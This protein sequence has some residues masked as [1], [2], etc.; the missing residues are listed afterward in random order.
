M[1]KTTEKKH[2]RK[3]PITPVQAFAEAHRFLKNAKETIAKSPIEHS[4]YQDTK[5]VREA[6][7]IAYLSALRAMDAYLLKKGLRDDEL[8]KSYEGY[9]AAKRKYIPLN[10]KLRDYLTIVYENLHIPAYYDG[11]S[12]V[13]VV[14]E[15]FAKC[16]L[17][18]EMLEKL[19]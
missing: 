4:R 13:V 12:S 11:A 14:K 17:I 3:E 2:S 10:G 1:K 18:I 15:G 8:P 9:W 6:A 16:K 5:Y 7:G 19:K